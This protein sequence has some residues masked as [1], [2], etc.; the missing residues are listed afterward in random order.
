MQ[1]ISFEAAETIVRVHLIPYF[2]EMTL[3]KIN[4]F[5]IDHLYAHKLNDGMAPATVHKIQNP[6]QNPFRKRVSSFYVSYFYRH[7]ARRNSCPL[8]K[9]CK[10]RKG[11]IH[12]E[13]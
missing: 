1:I 2:N 12:V 7:A 10:L 3:N 5:D 13:E 11:D 9:K 4:A 8:M 6:S